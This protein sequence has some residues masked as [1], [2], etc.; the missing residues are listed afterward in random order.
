MGA[1]S[2]CE[3]LPEKSLKSSQHDSLLACQNQNFQ[4]P[5]EMDLNIPSLKRQAAVLIFECLTLWS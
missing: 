5:L 1:C 4:V 3:V 2:I